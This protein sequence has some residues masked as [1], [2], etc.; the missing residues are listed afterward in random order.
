VR[1]AVRAIYQHV[2]SPSP[3]WILDNDDRGWDIGGRDWSTLTVLHA[4]ASID[5]PKVIKIYFVHEDNERLTDVL[6]SGTDYGPYV[7]DLLQNIRVPITAVRVYEGPKLI[8]ERR[9]RMRDT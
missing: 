9:T 1:E 3:T 8:H 7:D 2:G 4:G 6:P 5:D